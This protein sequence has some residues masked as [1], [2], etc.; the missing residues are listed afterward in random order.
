MLH[1]DSS[2]QTTLTCNNT[3]GPGMTSFCY[4]I[5][6]MPQELNSC[7]YQWAHGKIDFGRCHLA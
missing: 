1:C 6:E 2:T 4:N 3:A 5:D 7:L